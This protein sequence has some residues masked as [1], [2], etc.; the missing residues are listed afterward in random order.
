MCL[1]FSIRCWSSYSVLSP[2]S[3]A[4]GEEAENI[5]SPIPRSCRETVPVQFMSGS[6]VDIQAMDFSLKAVAWWICRIL[7]VM[8]VWI[9]PLTTCVLCDQFSRRLWTW[10]SSLFWP[11]GLSKSNPSKWI[12]CWFGVWGFP[13]LEHFC[14]ASG[15]PV[16]EIH[17]KQ[18]TQPR[19]VLS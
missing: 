3:W 12:I 6:G 19:I 5:S 14:P 10:S 9:I 17:K 16:M 15:I 1:P 18:T 4:D 8:W 11:M 7:T 13:F 2:P